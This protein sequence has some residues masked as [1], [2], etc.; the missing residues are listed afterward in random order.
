MIRDD[1]VQKLKAIKE[2]AE[3]D[4]TGD[5]YLLCKASGATKGHTA[6]KYIR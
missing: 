5:I 2:K 4:E 1:A 3:R 6:D